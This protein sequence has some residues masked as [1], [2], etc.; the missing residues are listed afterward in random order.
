VRVF[1]A[2]KLLTA[3]D[4]AAIGRFYHFTWAPV[5]GN[6]GGSEVILAGG[7]ADSHHLRRGLAIAVQTTSAR[8]LRLTV[9]GSYNAPKL[10]PPA[11]RRGAA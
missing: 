3:V 8:T 9:R 11:I 1:G 10:T 7:F 5:P 6:L 4:P 2:N